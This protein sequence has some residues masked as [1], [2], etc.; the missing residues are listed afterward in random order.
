MANEKISQMPVATTPLAGTE[1]IPL[2]QSGVN[3]S[4]LASSLIAGPAGLTRTAIT[5]TPTVTADSGYATV[6]WTVDIVS[7]DPLTKY[8]VISL[9]SVNPAGQTGYTSY[10]FNIQF[11]VTDQPAKG[12][13]LY[14][15]LEA[16]WYTNTT[17]YPQAANYDLLLVL[18]SSQT[19]VGFNYTLPLLGNSPTHF[20]GLIGTD[21]PTSWILNIED[22]ATF[23]DIPQTIFPAEFITGTSYTLNTATDTRTLVLDHNFFG[24]GQLT[25]W[26]QILIPTN[27]QGAGPAGFKCRVFW[28]G[29]T[30]DEIPGTTTVIPFGLIVTFQTPDAAYMHANNN[31]LTDFGHYADLEL[32]KNHGSPYHTNEWGLF[33]YA[34]GFQTNLTWNDITTSYNNV[35]NNSGITQNAAVLTSDGEYYTYYE[36]NWGTNT[37]NGFDGTTFT[38][39]NGSPSP[40]FNAASEIVIDVTNFRACEMNDAKIFSID[41]TNPAGGFFNVTRVGYTVNDDTSTLTNVTPTGTGHTIKIVLLKNPYSTDQSSSGV[42]TGI[43]MYAYFQ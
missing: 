41:L 17:D 29:Q 6:T 16:D 5:P 34:Q 21:L 15:S 10:S 27:A 8:F 42:L 33:T 26:T 3:K 22:I 9:G 43:S 38:I 25:Q 28:L 35:M 37:N 7:T 39:V 11:N 30:N 1:L 24:G 32:L 12:A 2:V 20:T 23:E 36:Y 31:V 19:S 40:N 13:P 4:V 14:F 18:N